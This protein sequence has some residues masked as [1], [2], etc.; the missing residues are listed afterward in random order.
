MGVTLRSRWIVPVGGAP[1]EDGAVAIDGDQIV[2][3]GPWKELQA[4]RGDEAIDLGERILMPG[5]VNAHCHLDYTMMRWVISPQ[6]S[7]SQWI[8]RINALKRTLMD[9]DYLAAVTRGFTELRKWGTTTVANIESFP[10]LLVRMAP[11]P[12]RTWWFF[13]MIDI[14]QREPSEEMVAGALAFFTSRKGW[15]GGFGMSPHA[16]YTA[17]AQLYELAARV[18]EELQMPVTTHVAESWEEWEMFRHGRGEMHNFMRKLGREMEDCQQARTPL[19]HL[20]ACAALNHRWLLAHMNELDEGDFQW[21]ARRPPA[22]RPS[23]VHCPGSHGYFRHA[24]F[25]LQRLR[26]AGVNICLGTDSLAST[27][28]LSLFDEMRSLSRNHPSV[29]AEEIVAM[30]TLNGGRALGIPVGTLAPE[31]LA[32]LIALPF[33]G[34]ASQVYDAIV[35][36]RDPVRWMMVNGQLLPEN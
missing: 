2:A 1:I 32:D 26:E 16:P 22:S 12:I 18:A 11:P 30:A 6:R 10:E 36:H 24:A 28:S 13:E 23:V 20:A 14:R 29:T 4:E 17:S 25:P 31:N 3:V 19:A 35:T 34:D 15:I 33:S 7:F 8:Q 9:D 27:G 21:L 5:L